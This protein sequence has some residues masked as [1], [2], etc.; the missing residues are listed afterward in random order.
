MRSFSLWETI[1]LGAEFPQYMILQYGGGCHGQR[2]HSRSP[3]LT[4]TIR[5][6]SPTKALFVKNMVQVVTYSWYWWYFGQRQIPCSPW[7]W[8]SDLSIVYPVCDGKKSPGKTSRWAGQQLP[9][10]QWLGKCL[11]RIMLWSSSL[12]NWYIQPMFDVEIGAFEVVIMANTCSTGAT[13][14]WAFWCRHIYTVRVITLLVILQT[15]TETVC[16]PQS[17]QQIDAE[18]NTPDIV[19]IRPC[20]LF[21]RAKYRDM[22]TVILSVCACSIRRN[23]CDIQQCRRAQLW[24]SPNGRGCKRGEKWRHWTGTEGKSKLSGRLPFCRCRWWYYRVLLNRGLFLV[25]ACY[26]QQSIVFNSS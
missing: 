8:S 23:I 17:G 11:A 2:F 16:S 19:I 14:N 12:G 6:I 18:S 13:A 24:Y 15:V 1:Y 9:V 26:R 7:T 5:Q 3:T 10:Q 20:F 22:Q 25:G 4:E 21:D